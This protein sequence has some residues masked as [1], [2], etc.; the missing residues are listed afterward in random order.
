LVLLAALAALVAAVTIV[1][2]TTR[3]SG[4]SPV[5]GQSAAGD[6]SSAAN[7]GASASG[8]VTA[9]FQNS[10]LPANTADNVPIGYPHT[11][12]GAE[13]AAANYVVAYSSSAM[14]TPAARHELIDAIADPAIASSLQSQLDTAYSQVDSSLGLSAQG[15]APSG[16]TFV[17]R[18]APVGVTLVN[19]G[20]DAAT[21][22]VWTVTI[23]GLA[24][25]GSTHPV[26]ENW[27]TVTVTLHW[28]QGDW[29]WVS[30]S[31]ADGPVPAGGQQTVSG[32]QDLQKAV[33]QFGGLRYA[34]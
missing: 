4:G 15:V 20:G 6:G 27:S 18:S 30:F 25:T 19:N 23:A 26:A 29:K 22:S 21:V 5:S 10:G 32:S 3:H 7:A 28:T 31:A 14:V 8:P 12:K 33:S 34:R 2:H 24:G 13:S 16:Q 17:Q 1:N 9:P 11:A